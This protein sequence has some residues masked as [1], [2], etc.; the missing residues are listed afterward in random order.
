[1]PIQFI[2]RLASSFANPPVSRRI[3]GTPS[4]PNFS[5][6]WPLFVTGM[7]HRLLLWQPTSSCAQE[8]RSSAL[9]W[10]LRWSVPGKGTLQCGF[11]LV[12]TAVSQVASSSWP[13]LSQGMDVLGA[14]LV[15]S[16]KDKET[17][18][19]LML[20]MGG[21]SGRLP[22]IIISRFGRNR[23]APRH[24]DIPNVDVRSHC[25]GSMSTKLTLSSPL[26]FSTS[27]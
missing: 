26:R 20:T 3:R 8:R 6:K 1:M 25:E 14:I 16:N 12:W 17:L 22:T 24:V 9:W 2:S 11:S 27:F 18:R 4:F 7:P 21:R 10:S 19:R 5:K 15:T 13:V 23:V